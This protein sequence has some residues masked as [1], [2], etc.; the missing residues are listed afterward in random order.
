MVCNH[1]LW[2]WLLILLAETAHLAETVH[3]QPA[4][5]MHR[6]PALSLLRDPQD[7]PLAAPPNANIA[8]GTAAGGR[9]DLTCSSRS[10]MR[11]VLGGSSE[12]CPNTD[13]IVSAFGNRS[14]TAALATGTTIFTTG[15]LGNF[16]AG[17]DVNVAATYTLSLRAGATIVASCSVTAPTRECCAA[18]GY[19]LTTP[20]SSTGF[21]HAYF[22]Q[23]SGTNAACSE[24]WWSASYA[25]F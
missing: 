2:F 20:I 7:C 16:C 6:S 1:M 23:V 24:A 8:T 15:Y 4:L 10:P 14:D 13:F 3:A 9:L 18:P 22:D 11:S 17:M 5:Q 25:I 21:V 12:T 19:Y